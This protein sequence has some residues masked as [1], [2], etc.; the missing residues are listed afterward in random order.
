MKKTAPPL[1]EALGRAHAALLADLSRLEEAARPSRAEGPPDLR[2]H[3]QAT[4]AHILEHFRFE[5]RNGYMDGVVERAPHLER[6]VCELAQEHRH[7]K[8]SLD[9]LL[10]EAGPGKGRDEAY[11][12]KILHW[13]E[14]VRRHETRENELVQDAFNLDISPE[15]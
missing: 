14:R 10:A 3:L 6:V 5:E 13:L 2:Q 7:L 11:C 15:D 4:R 12:A 8:E 9:A 1:A